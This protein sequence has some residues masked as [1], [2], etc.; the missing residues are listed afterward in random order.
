MSVPSAGAA[1]C[2]PTHTCSFWLKPVWLDR[3]VDMLRRPGATF[4]DVVSCCCHRT[5][6]RV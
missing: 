5:L 4:G 6:L 3:A 1:P 2:L